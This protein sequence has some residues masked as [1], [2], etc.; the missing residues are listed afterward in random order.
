MQFETQR[1][2]LRPWHPTQD[3]RHAMDIFGAQKVMN[4][5]EPAD[6]DTNLRQVQN[7]LQR[8]AE[9]TRQAK[10]GTGSWAVVQKDIGRVIGHIILMPL[11]DIKEVRSDHVIEPIEDGLPT[12]Y[13]EIG[14]HFRPAS[15]G[16]GYAKEAAY[17]IMQHAFSDLM[18]PMLLAVAYPDN[19]RSIALMDR[20]GMKD[21]GVTT[22]LYGGQILRLY[23]MG[24][25]FFLENAQSEQS[26]QSAQRAQ[27]K[28]NAKGSVQPSV[29][30]ETTPLQAAPEAA[31]EET[32]A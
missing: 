27:S 24:A 21:E 9:Q 26:T 6:I 29:Q 11:P 25:E 17:C 1:L 7:R 8:Y 18:L 4:W 32:P 28:Q 16:F 3:A 19:H 22:R 15:W 2:R 31:P 23:V 10:N 14:W 30:T 20:L 12:D 5:V 13:I